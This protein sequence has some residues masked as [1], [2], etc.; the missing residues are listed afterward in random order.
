MTTWDA[1]RLHVAHLGNRGDLA[2][3]KRRPQ[4][5]EIIEI[6]ETVAASG[7]AISTSR[8][9]DG[10]EIRV[11][12]RLEAGMN[13]FELHARVSTSTEGECRR[14][15]DAVVEPLEIDVHAVFVGDSDTESETYPVDADWVDV[16]AVIREELMLAL[17][18]SPLCDEGCVGADPERFPARTVPADES[19]T[20]SETDPRWDVLSQLT[21]DED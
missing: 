4:G 2:V 16:G 8:I 3:L 12:G 10:S 6:D 1:L 7:L 14:C 19:G 21:F 13:E 11:S 17:P 5:A 18:L 15:L 20:S 9:P